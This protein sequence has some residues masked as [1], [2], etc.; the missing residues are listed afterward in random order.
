LRPATLP[1]RRTCGFPHPAVEASGLTTRQIRS[2]RISY[3]AV[4]QKFRKVPP[5]DR[6]RQARHGSAVSARCTLRETTV[7]VVPFDFRSLPSFP[8]GSSLA[9]PCSFR[10]SLHGRYPASSLLRRLLTSS[11]LS[12][13]RSPQ[14]R[15]GIFPLA[16]PGST[17]CI[18]DDFWASLLPASWPRGHPA[19]TRPHCRFVF[20][21]A[22][23][24]EGAP[25]GEFAIRFFQL[26]PLGC[27]LRFRYGCRHRL[28][29]DP[30]I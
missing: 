15:C 2:H 3:I 16:P 10:P 19:G 29:L 12:R 21:G 6:R 23:G 22:P 4:C 5:R 30:F 14:V 9:L 20:L 8:S 24:P 26:S 13:R 28:R 1:H 17:W 25:A 18:S 11:P 27:A 7:V